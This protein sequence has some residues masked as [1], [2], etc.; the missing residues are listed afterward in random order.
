M[1]GIEFKTL[2]TINQVEYINNQLSNGNSVDNIRIELGVGKN[3]IANTL[4]S[5]GYKLDRNINQY[6]IT[7]DITTVT[8]GK[9]NKI[10]TGI[11][12]I[13]TDTKKANK[14]A[15]EKNK[16][17][18]N[19][20]VLVDRID[21]L[22]RELSTIKAMLN[23]Y[24]ITTDSTTTITTDFKTYTGDAIARNYRVDADIQQQFKLFCK[25]HKE[26]RVSD[27]LSHAIEEYI[28]KRK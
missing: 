5:K 3:Y 21:T 6:V 19:N 7:T 11:T 17:A 8:T 12:T 9:T 2:D 27:L 26:H 23:N 4:K 22:E 13:T 20:K 18:S 1:N 24:G 14:K 25:Q 15:I 28:N 16:D 10:T